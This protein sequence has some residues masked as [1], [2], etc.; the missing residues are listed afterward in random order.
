[1]YYF[2]PDKIPIMALMLH[3]DLVCHYR[4]ARCVFIRQATQMTFMSYVF[5]SETRNQYQ[6][7]HLTHM[8]GR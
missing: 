1:M 3:C 5:S 8:L 2:R 6:Q 4:C 7:L